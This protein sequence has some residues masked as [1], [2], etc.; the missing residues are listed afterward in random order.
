MVR[1][2]VNPQQFSPQTA[3]PATGITEEEARDVAAYLYAR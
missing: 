2:I 3:M 1:W